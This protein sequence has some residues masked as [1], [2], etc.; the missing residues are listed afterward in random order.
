VC[1]IEIGERERER[2]R[3]RENVEI[4]STKRGMD[5]KY[6]YDVWAGL[7]EQG[8]LQLSIPCPLVN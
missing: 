3:E 7:I 1:K 4:K 2:E 5:R 6:L 8:I